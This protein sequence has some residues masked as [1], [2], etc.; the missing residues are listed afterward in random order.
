MKALRIQNRIRPVGFFLLIAIYSI[1]LNAQTETNSEVKQIEPEKNIEKLYG[2]WT[3]IDIERNGKKV[4]A[5]DQGDYYNSASLSFCQPIKYPGAKSTFI[6][7]DSCN[8]HTRWNFEEDEQGQVIF[9]S[10]VTQRAMGLIPANY[11][12]AMGCISIENGSFYRN[13]IY[14]LLDGFQVVWISSDRIVVE[15]ESVKMTC[16]KA[17]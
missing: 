12:T 13:N 17:I 10:V 16:T 11:V 8:T 9:P 2:Q 4:T 14:K 5:P 3:I 6:F 7:F 1:S 15:N